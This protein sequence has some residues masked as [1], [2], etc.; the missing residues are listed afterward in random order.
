ML[1]DLVALE[2]ADEMPAGGRRGCRRGVRWAIPVLPLEEFLR[3]GGVLG[4]H[5]LAVFAEIDVA[6]GEK[7][8][9]LVD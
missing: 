3:L 7:L 2:V 4:E 1:A 5:L 9:N 6:E 8:A